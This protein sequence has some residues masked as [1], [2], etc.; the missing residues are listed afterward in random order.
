MLCL[1]YNYNN[2]CFCKS[3]YSK[4][5]KQK[6]HLKFRCVFYCQKDLLSLFFVAKNSDLSCGCL[7]NLKVLMEYII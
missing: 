3:M 7:I 1:F 4:K 2:I 6:A 5:I